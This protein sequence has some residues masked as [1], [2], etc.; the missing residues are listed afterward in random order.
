VSTESK[1][2]DISSIGRDTWIAGVGALALFLGP[3][4]AWY[5]ASLGPIS[6]S[7][8]GWDETF[9][10]KLCVLAG[11]AALVL[12]VMEVLEKPL[13]QLP[14][15]KAEALLALGAIGVVLMVIKLLDYLFTF[16]DGVDLSFGFFV[17]LIGAGALAWVGWSTRAA[18]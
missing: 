15:S 7:I 5:S 16:P 1:P 11:L 6:V 8:S 2:F 4:L 3:F 13:P 12:I 14:V 10:A 9:L 18:D 17:T